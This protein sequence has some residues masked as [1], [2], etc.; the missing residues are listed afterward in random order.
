MEVVKDIKRFKKRFKRFQY[1][2]VI[3]KQLYI[4]NE[5][6]RIWLELGFPYQKDENNGY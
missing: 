2:D 5:V 6:K 1:D 3:E 4:Q